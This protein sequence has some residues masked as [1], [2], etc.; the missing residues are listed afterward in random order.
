MKTIIPATIAAAVTQMITMI[1]VI[2]FVLFS[3][4]SVISV[5]AYVSVA[6]AVCSSVAGADDVS[7]ML[8]SS[9]GMSSSCNVPPGC[10]AD[11]GSFKKSL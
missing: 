11:D 5:S 8:S 4:L 2:S 9:V 7:V 3:P 1:N 6:N 10:V